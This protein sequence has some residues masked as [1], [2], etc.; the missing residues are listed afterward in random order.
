VTELTDEDKLKLEGLDDA[1]ERFKE[2]LNEANG[3][4]GK[5]YT[6]LKSEVDSQIDDFKKD[7]MENKR[8]FQQQA[9]YAVN[10]D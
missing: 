5:S 7:C 10:K 8:T 6:S 3:M 2:G 9:P 1:W 4:I